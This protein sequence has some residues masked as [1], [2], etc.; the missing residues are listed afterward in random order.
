[1]AM[2]CM[3]GVPTS[4]SLEEMVEKNRFHKGRRGVC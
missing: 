2:I 3:E 4:R 1:M